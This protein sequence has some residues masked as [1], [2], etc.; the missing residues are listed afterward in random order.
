MIFI[1]TEAGSTEGMGH[2]VRL[3]ALCQLLEIENSVTVCIKTNWDK[4]Q[5]AGI[6][7]FFKQVSFFKT[8]VDA[9]NEIP[10]GSI[11]FIDAYTFNVDEIN[12]YKAEKNWKLLFIADVHLRVPDADILV[13]H[14][15]WISE[16]S[17]PDASIGKML[18]G[19]KYAILRE[20][21]YKKKPV[22]E[23]DSVF[24]CLGG[25]DV[26]QQIMNIYNGLLENGFSEDKINV[27]YNRPL[28]N[29][30]SENLFLNLGAEDVYSLISKANLCF[31]A[32]GNISYEVFSIHKTA[33]MGHTSTTQ[34]DVA[35]KF[36][37]IGL[38]YNIGSWATADFSQLPVWI[39]RAKQ[40]RAIQECFF[41]RSDYLYLKSDLLSFI[42]Y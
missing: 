17:Y 7:F 9:V 42:R 26:V 3:F 5:C 32:P 24:I 30:K 19:S 10:Y 27:L 38:C 1:L 8:E 33:I 25:A 37:D 20:A 31:I 39:D 34:V 36:N 35:M 16:E 40:T 21:F 22:Q 28:D 4:E 18:T 13:N 41:N 6:D 12:R 14:L 2:V 15:P 23:E 11:V 29:V